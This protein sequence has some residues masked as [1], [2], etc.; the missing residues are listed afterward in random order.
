MNAMNRRE[1]P[2]PIP[3]ARYAMADAADIEEGDIVCLNTGWRG[4]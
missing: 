4:C 1:L 3:L 2:E